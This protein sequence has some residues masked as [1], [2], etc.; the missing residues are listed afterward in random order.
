MN[1]DRQAKHQPAPTRATT[2]QLHLAT[3]LLLFSKNTRHLNF[4]F[5]PGTAADPTLHEKKVRTE[6]EN[7]KTSIVVLSYVT[8]CST[9]THLFVRECRR[10]PGGGLYQVADQTAEG[11]H[12][13][14]G[15]GEGWRS[16]VDG[17]GGLNHH[18]VGDDRGVDAWVGDT[19]GD[20][21]GVVGDCR[22]G[23]GT[24]EC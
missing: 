10:R 19:G 5:H 2:I 18:G 20:E 4:P 12:E 1:A 8:V 11:K 23:D 13:A 22:R 3:H 24:G 16:A 21:G 17:R 7:S 15:T 6:Q 9:S 14:W